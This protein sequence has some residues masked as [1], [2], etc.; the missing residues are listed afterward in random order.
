M[1]WYSVCQFS[2]SVKK[3]K[4]L[5]DVTPSEDFKTRTMTIT[6]QMGTTCVPN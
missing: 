6:N 4:D 3:K 1:V 2:A 5:T